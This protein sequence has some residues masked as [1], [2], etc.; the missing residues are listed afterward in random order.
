E[1]TQDHHARTVALGAGRVTE[2][3]T[4]SSSTSSSRSAP[5]LSSGLFWLPHLGDCTHEGQPSKHSHAAMVSRVAVSQSR[6]AAKPRSAKPA[7]PGWPSYTKTVSWPVS[8][9]MAVETPPMSHRSQVAKSG[10]TPLEQC[11]A[12]CAEPG[13]S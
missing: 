2:P 10:S 5:A 6:A 9:C 8:G 13:S 7:P 1:Q 12:A 4:G 3:Q 11:S